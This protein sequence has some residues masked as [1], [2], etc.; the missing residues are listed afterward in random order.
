MAIKVLMRSALVSVYSLQHYT[1]YAL[2]FDVAEKT[3]EL[4]IQK[5]ERFGAFLNVQQRQTNSTLDSL[6]RQP[7]LRIPVYTDILRRLVACIGKESALRLAIEGE[8]AKWT[9]LNDTLT[10]NHKLRENEERLASIDLSFPHD[11]LNLVPGGSPD[12]RTDEPPRPEK[13]WSMVGAAFRATASSLRLSRTSLSA[14]EA[15]YTRHEWVNWR[16]VPPDDGAGPD[17]TPPRCFLKE[18]DIGF[19]TDCRLRKLFLL[20]DQVVIGKPQTGNR[21]VWAPFVRIFSLW[22]GLAQ[23]Y[24]STHSQRWGSC[25]VCRYAL[26]HRLWLPETWIEVA[27]GPELPCSFVVGSPFHRRVMLTAASL[28]LRNKWADAIQM[29]ILESRRTVAPPAPCRITV[30]PYQEA[31]CGTDGGDIGLITVDAGPTD[32][33]AMVIEAVVAMIP[34]DK[35]GGWQKI[36]R[37][38]IELSTHG[39]LPLLSGDVPGLIKTVGARCHMLRTRCQFVL[40]PHTASTLMVDMLPTTLQCL[41]THGPV[42]K[43]RPSRSSTPPTGGGDGGGAAVSQ[44]PLS[45]AQQHDQVERKKRKGLLGKMGQKMTAGIKTL[46][47]RKGEKSDSVTS[48]PTFH[49]R[50]DAAPPPSGRLYGR[51]LADLVP[52]TDADAIPI[53]L[54]GIIARLYY[55]GPSASGLFRKSANARVIKQVRHRL[56]SGVDVDWSALPIL[57]VGAVLKEFLR[58]L[59]DS[60]MTLRLY[61]D[62]VGCNEVADS[63]DRL[64]QVAAALKRLPA[65]HA[66]LLRALIPMFVRI[67]DA[68][69]ANGMTAGNVGICIGQSL[70]WP[71]TMEE[72]LKNDVPPFIEV[73]G[74]HTPFAL[75]CIDRCVATASLTRDSI[76][77]P[78]LTTTN[79]SRST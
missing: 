18:G 74:S 6:V 8:Y 63:A 47:G 28:S 49:A 48:S 25:H 9:D 32:T 26:V 21:L 71:S 54:Q 31:L 52:S 50:Q 33:A 70:M 76:P 73:G 78:P 42:E 46:H 15:E 14:V 7:L 57:A 16:A 3:I 61:S 77:F 19:G 66:T 64:T 59:P 67:C 43:A 20:N 5:H 68:G 75:G 39:L 24:S 65:G 23:L 58:S 34:A 12:D 60:V 41:V 79:A 37:Q 53:P 38:L 56:E 72:I 44:S 13:R 17:P 10:K 45:A 2:S 35:R 62:F 27:L 36:N 55:D 11:T 69:E 30:Y 29:A 51:E 40:F 22:L 1:R 4:C